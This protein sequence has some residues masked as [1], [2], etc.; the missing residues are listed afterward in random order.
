MKFLAVT[1]LLCGG[2][3]SAHGVGWGEQIRMMEE[4][5]STGH[6]RSALGL[7]SR[8]QEISREKGRNYVDCDYGDPDKIKYCP[9]AHQ[10]PLPHL[11]SNNPAIVVKEKVVDEHVASKKASGEEVAPIADV[12]PEVAVVAEAM[13][14]KS[15]EVAKA[16]EGEPEDA[17][18]VFARCLDDPDDPACK[19]LAG[20]GRG[21]TGSPPGSAPVAVL[22]T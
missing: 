3:G 18:V 8:V 16:E 10:D 9:G 15:Q 13:E 21:L 22:S 14:E 19:E 20:R 11:R 4:A 1:A 6:P 7:G 2:I 12:D 17:L 5:E